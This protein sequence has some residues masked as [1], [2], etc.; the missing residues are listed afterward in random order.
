M[1]INNKIIGIHKEGS[2]EYGYF[3]K[4]NKGTFLNFPIKDF[5]KN[6]KAMKNY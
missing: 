1:N 3:S 4:F 2:Q 5:I 6:L